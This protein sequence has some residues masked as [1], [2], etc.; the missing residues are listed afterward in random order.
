MAS[1]LAD[2]SVVVATRNRSA[3]LI[4]TLKTLELQTVLPDEILIVDASD[5]DESSRVMASLAVLKNRLKWIN[6]LS[7][8][9]ASQRMEGISQAKH[10]FILLMDDDIDMSHDVLEK[11]LRG[12]SLHPSAGA[13]NAMITNQRYTKPR[14]VSRTMYHVMHGKKLDTYAGKLIGPAWNLLPEDDD[15]LGEYVQCEWLNTTCTLYHKRALPNPVF[16]SHFKGYSLLEDVSLSVTIGRKFELWNARTARIYHN[17]QT[18]DHKNNQRVISEMQLVNRYYVMTRV[19]KRSSISMKMKLVLL[20]LF[21]IVTGIR[22][23]GGV[24]GLLR[25]LQGKIDGVKVIYRL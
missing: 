9:A 22:H 6:A 14:W 10:P 4:Q 8:G 11:L 5:S 25:V 18:G 23:V 7:R 17:S 3:S 1:K 20:E 24:N 13:V 19:L 2:V 21:G 15:R 16:D 12:F